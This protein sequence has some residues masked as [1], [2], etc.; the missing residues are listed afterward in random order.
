MEAQPQD[1]MLNRIT[2]TRGVWMEHQ[3][4]C[5]HGTEQGEERERARQT[6]RV[7]RKSAAEGTNEDI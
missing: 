4:V 7:E 2:L 6:D 5:K 1:K 3:K